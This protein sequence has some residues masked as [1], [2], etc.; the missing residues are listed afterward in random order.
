MNCSVIF[1]IF[2]LYKGYTCLSM[3]TYNTYCSFIVAAVFYGNYF[4]VYAEIWDRC[5]HDPNILIVWYED[6]IR[7]SKT[8][9]IVINLKNEKIT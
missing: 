9:N 1:K 2:M 3:P 5:R 4:E 7:V 8:S 6:L